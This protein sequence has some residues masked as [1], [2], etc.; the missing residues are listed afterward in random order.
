MDNSKKIIN[1]HTVQFL[2]NTKIAVAFLHLKY[3]I[4]ALALMIYIAVLYGAVPGLM[5]PSGLSVWSAGFA[6]S[7]AQNSN[8]SPYA[9]NIGYPA[10]A[11]VAYG[12]S[13]VYLES[14]F[15]RLGMDA[16]NA[17][18]AMFLTWLTL[19]FWGAYKLARRLAASISIA[20]LAAAL[21]LICPTIYIHVAGY[22]MLGLGMA[23]LPFYTWCTLR[24]CET[25]KQQNICSLI[26]FGFC[27][28]LA[29]FMDGYTYIMFF[30]IASIIILHYLYKYRNKINKRKIL[31]LIIIYICSFAF[32]YFMYALFIG[33]VAYPEHPLERFRSYGSDI[34]YFLIP[35]KGVYWIYDILNISIN[36]SDVDHFG[37]ASIWRTTFLLPA[38]IATIPAAA[39]KHPLR[40]VFIAIAILGIYL[41]LGPTLKF[42]TLRPL[43]GPIY[44]PDTMGI[45]PTGSAFLDKYVPGFNVMRASYRWVALAWLALWSLIILAVTSPWMKRHAVGPYIML[46]ALIILNLP[47]IEQQVKNKINLRTSLIKLDRELVE[48]LRELLPEK[49][50]VIFLPATNDFGLTYVAPRA[51]FYSCNIGGDKNIE[52]A[53][54]FWPSVITSTLYNIV[55][56]QCELKFVDNI[57]NEL[58]NGA[59]D[60]IVFIFFNGR[61]DGL[62]FINAIPRIHIMESLAPILNKLDNMNDID[63]DIK[64][65]F[66]LVTLCKDGKE[67]RTDFLQRFA[68]QLEHNS[69]GW[70]SNKPLNGV[71][72]KFGR[73]VHK[74]I[75]GLSGF[76]FGEISHRWSVDSK[77]TIYFSAPLPLDGK[78]S[79]DAAAFKP[80]IGKPFILHIGEFSHI[81]ILKDTFE[82]IDIQYA[83]KSPTNKITIDIPS[84]ASPRSLGLSNDD[85]PLGISVKTI[86]IIAK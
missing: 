52:F 27:C 15:I 86:S 44:M 36:R 21:W 22:V 13:G 64:K 18:A 73:N 6:E 29:V 43:N 31:L 12:L 9:H 67:K 77:A 84:P 30:C 5:L 55:W 14:L 57:Y 47:H 26:L 61:D 39:N 38:F 35:T 68:N 2:C 40:L 8:F 56:R 63:I 83:V 79:I 41:S 16:P 3:I 75:L 46:V 7:I 48:P 17:D 34:S 42:F 11:P 25:A 24:L 19:A 72:I 20:I 76:S 51:K 74:E 60:G 37:S 54:P 50:R 80:N 4:L 71:A 69:S 53:R 78:I 66:A 81:F 32:A 85:R 58:R 33:K 59:F 45:F 62:Q 70:K 10:P 82:T 1:S 65:W 49:S 28:L 23:L